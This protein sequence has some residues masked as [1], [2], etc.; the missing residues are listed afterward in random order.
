MRYD[1]FTDMVFYLRR[2]S[3]VITDMEHPQASGTTLGVAITGYSFDAVITIFTS[4][5]LLALIYHLSNPFI[6]DL[7]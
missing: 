4:V 5:I 1:V 3:V 6:R 7:V 2:F